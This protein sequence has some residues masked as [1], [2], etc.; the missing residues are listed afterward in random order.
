MRGEARGALAAA[1]VVAAFRTRAR[2]CAPALGPPCWHTQAPARN[3]EHVAAAGCH[4]GAAAG[5]PG[6]RRG[7]GS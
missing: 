7:V 2:L 5:A 4:V 3:F 1:A 6:C